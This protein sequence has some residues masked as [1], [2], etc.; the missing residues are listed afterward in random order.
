MWGVLPVALKILLDNI[1]PLTLT[2]TRFLVAALLLGGFLAWRQR[3]P[4]RGRLGRNGWVLLAVCAL[5]L[6]GNYL[7]YVFGLDRVTPATSQMVIQLAPVFLLVGGL[8]LFR[9]PFARIQWGGFLVLGLGLLLFFNDRFGDLAEG[10]GRYYAGVMITVIA[11]ISWAAY[12]LAQKR[13]LRRLA[14]DQ[15]LLLV[16]AGSALALLPTARPGA[17]TG[18]STLALALLIMACLNT[19]V[20]YGAFAEALAHWEA[21]R[22]S[23]V[24]SITPLLTLTTSWLTEQISPG[25]IVPDRINGLSLMGAVLVVAGSA[26]TALGGQVRRRSQPG[27]A[28]P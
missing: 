25:L 16:Y 11:A 20:A 19:L 12:A 15:I 10:R 14:S 21:S 3:L 17:L 8:V 6:V 22:V 28:R 23:A 27:S 13:L 4:P 2:W 9:E 7:L 1:D 24:L 5:G 26:M 18:L